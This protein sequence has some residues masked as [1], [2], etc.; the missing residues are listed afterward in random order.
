[1]KEA[2]TKVTVHLPMALL[3]RARAIT[4]EGVTGTVRRGLQQ[5]AAVH[6]QQRLRAL[7][8]KVPFALDVETLRED[9]DPDH[10]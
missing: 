6:A 7:R 2:T 1:M 10:R 4:G 3:Q 9:R 8:G 5:I